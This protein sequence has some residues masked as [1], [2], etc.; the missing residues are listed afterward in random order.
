MTR[1]MRTFLLCGAAAA[2]AMCLLLMHRQAAAHRRNAAPSLPVIPADAALLSLDWT[3][4]GGESAE[5]AFAFTLTSENGTYVLSDGENS[6]SLTDEQRR[7]VEQTLRVGE[8]TAPVELPEGV[9]VL[10]AVESTLSVTWQRT[11]SKTITAVY[12]GS[13]EAE[14]RQLLFGFLTAE[15]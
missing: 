8:H 13:Y 7:Q 5:G 6:V 11:D 2:I 1:R 3:Q 14:L 4:T 12:D 15:P 9:E 10:D